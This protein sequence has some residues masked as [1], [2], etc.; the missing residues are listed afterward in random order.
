MA[1]TRANKAEKKR[2]KKRKV[3]TKKTGKKPKKSDA[4]YSAIKSKIKTVKKSIKK[5]CSAIDNVAPPTVQDSTVN[6]VQGLASSQSWVGGLVGT[7]AGI[8]YKGK[9][10]LCGSKS[11]R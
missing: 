6:A 9:K 1:K 8:L 11:F 3:T 4:I 2:A 7:G 5:V 10:T